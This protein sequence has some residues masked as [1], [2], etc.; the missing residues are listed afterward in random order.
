MFS[1]NLTGLRADTEINVAVPTLVLPS[2]HWVWSCFVHLHLPSVSHHRSNV[3]SD[4]TFQWAMFQVCGVVWCGSQQ[5][6]EQCLMYVSLW[7]EEM[8]PNGL[9]P[10]RA[11]RWVQCRTAPCA[12]PASTPSS[13]LPDFFLSSTRV[14]CSNAL[15]VLMLALLLFGFVLWVDG[16]GV[17]ACLLGGFFVCFSACCFT[18]LF[19]CGVLHSGKLFLWMTLPRNKEWADCPS[20]KVCTM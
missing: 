4:P 11:P 6:L 12:H 16:G 1:W 19:V 3:P 15:W 20:H 5:L 8:K 14:H 7:A 13:H 18:C 9:Q 2:T 17:F 10:G